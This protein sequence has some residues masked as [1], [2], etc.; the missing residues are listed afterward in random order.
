MELIPDDHALVNTPPPVRVDYWPHPIS[1][2]GRTILV[3]DPGQT[4]AQVFKGLI[5]YGETAIA[6]VNGKAVPMEDWH[7]TIVHP[8]DV[9]Q[10]RLLVGDGGGSNPI[11]VVLSIAFLVTLGPTGLIGGAIAGL[12]F[13]TTAT[14]FITAAAGTL[15]IIAI[16][17]LFPPRLPGTSGGEQPEPLYSLSGGAN[18]A[19]PYEP[20]R[21][22]LGRHRVF[23]DLVAQEYLEYDSEG[24]QYLNLILDCGLGDLELGDIYYRESL[25]SS[26][27]NVEIQTGVEKVTLVKGN[28]DTLEGGDMGY[29]VGQTNVITRRTAGDTTRLCFDL[30]VRHVRQRSSGRQE[31]KPVSVTLRYRLKD[32][33][34]WT[35]HSFDIETPSGNESRNPTRRS[36][37][38]N[39]PAGEYD[40]EAYTRN[41]YAADA[42]LKKIQ[43]DAH[44]VSFRAMQDE[45]ANFRGRNPIAI[46]IKADGQISGRFERVSVE[47]LN[48]LN[49]AK[50]SNPADVLLYWYKGFR[51][52]GILAAGYGM[53]DDEIN[54][55]QIAAFK[56]HCT[57]HNLTINVNIEDGRDEEEVARL[58]CQCGWGRIDTSTGKYGVLF[59]DDGVPVTA[60]VTP[61][62][63]IAGS[64]NETW[65]NQNLADEMVGEFIDAESDYQVN[66]LRRFVPNSGTRGEFPVTVRLE[67][68]TNGEQAAKEI[69]RA[70]AAQFYHTRTTT[71][72]MTEAGIAAIGVGDVVGMAN[73]L[74]GAGRKGG[75]FRSIS[76]DR[77]TIELLRKD[78]DAPGTIWIWALDDT[79]FNTTFELV[80]DDDG[81]VIAGQIRLAKPLPPPFEY[82]DD[83]PLAYQY[84]AFDPTDPYKKVRIVGIEPSQG[85]TSLLPA[86]RYRNTTMPAQRT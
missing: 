17:T 8:S 52:D 21:I 5:P 72:E 67:G 54:M 1:S 11:A 59:E 38:Y 58:I 15:G 42:D 31:G 39:V 56:A 78:L 62:N 82:T 70:A 14:A 81:N 6:S 65:E 18:R 57:K 46:R 64:L 63:I 80:R 55:E 30:A 19:R 12:G 23:P 48:R 10:M 28:V 51:I 75:R 50:S 20:M 7:R 84:M 83:D 68:I 71:W 26:Y 69:N 27:N 79:V 22:T 25:L 40:V 66:T 24:D 44:I 34:A 9:I 3:A 74:T 61:D 13:G 60:L 49:G 53:G 35:T 36:Y 47:V 29:I 33:A 37:C 45:T 73:G 76:E 43:V 2:D 85:S 32:A 77:R 16:N 86:R 41:P 4:L